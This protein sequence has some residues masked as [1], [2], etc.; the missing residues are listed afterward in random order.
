MSNIITVIPAAGESRRYREAGYPTIKPLLTVR[1]KYGAVGSML[2]HVE[3]S[4]LTETIVALPAQVMKPID[5]ISRVVAIFRTI[6]QADTVYQLVRS[7]PPSEAV[8]VMDCDMILG[9][10]DV[11][12]LMQYL[13]LYDM[14]VAV[15]ES[16]DPNAS[17]VDTVPFPTRFIEKEP[18][19]QWGIVGVRAFRKAG[20]LANALQITIQNCIKF[21]TEPYLSTA[22]NNYPGTKYAH[23]IQ[24]YQDWGTPERLRESGAEII[25]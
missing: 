3:Q 10:G 13:E 1:N 23:V 18:I 17:R 19:S 15:T 24:N 8:V 7:L 25:G 20:M 16:F 2:H 9:I 12:T 6:G 4:A 21:D 11:H 22:M 5:S 14:V